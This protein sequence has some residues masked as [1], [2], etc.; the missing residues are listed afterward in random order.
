MLRAIN[1]AQMPAVKELVNL[2][3]DDN[4]GPNETTLLPWTTARTHTQTKHRSNEERQP[5]TADKIGGHI[6]TLTED[7]MD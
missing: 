6:T 4:K 5:I 3:R 1:R 7:T 2:M